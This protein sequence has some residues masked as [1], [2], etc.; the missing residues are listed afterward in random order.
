MGYEV[1]FLAVGDESSGGDAIALR[2]GNLHGDRS[3]QTVIVIDGGYQAN[4]QELVDLIRTHYHTEVVD[5]VVS[6]HPDQDH[7]SGL[8]VVLEQLTVGTLLMHRP[9]M[10]SSDVRLSKSAG[11]ASLAASDAKLAKSFQQA[12]DLE[13]LAL[14]KGVQIIEPF[15]G[16]ATQDGCF[17]IVGPS[18]DYYE[19]LLKDMSTPKSAL[20]RVLELAREAKQAVLNLIDET[21]HHE[22]LRDDGETSATNNSSVIALFEVDGRRLLFTGDAGIPALDRAMAVLESDGFT[23]GSLRLVQVPH[24]G[25]RRNVGPTI[26]NRMLGHQVHETPH[27][28]A[29]VSAP[30]KNPEHKHPSKKVTNVYRRRGYDVHGTQGIRLRYAAGAP[31]REGYTASTPIPFHSKVEDDSES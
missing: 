18:E 21:L 28:H 7:V 22:T 12:S 27:S 5:I 14:K 8:E 13:T 2:Y 11:F 15:E 1:D 25:S 9:W 31:D 24:H 3:Q 10:H 6:T 17:R 26:L 4:G 29:V 20:Q 30:V 23:P 19:S 16:L